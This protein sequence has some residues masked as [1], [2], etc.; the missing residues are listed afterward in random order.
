MKCILLFTAIFVSCHTL[1][2]PLQAPLLTVKARYLII[3]YGAGAEMYLN[4]ENSVQAMYVINAYSHTPSIDLTTES[5][6]ITEYRKY[7]KSPSIQKPNKTYIAPY[8]KYSRIK[9]GHGDISPHEWMPHKNIDH[10]IGLVIGKRIL[11][12]ERRKLLTDFFI[13]PQL[14]YRRSTE[15][16]INVNSLDYCCK[17]A[18]SG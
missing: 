4:K 17:S 15:Q 5:A 12:G 14:G 11:L 3:S 10:N 2:Q 18:S 9:P 7:L 13:G 1:A 8:Y 6:F 16:L